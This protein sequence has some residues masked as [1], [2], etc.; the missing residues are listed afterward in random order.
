MDD[1]TKV[2]LILSMVLTCDSLL[3]GR[4]IIM[5]TSR[6]TSSGQ[7][8][9]PEWKKV[10]SKAGCFL[11]FC[12]FT[13][14]MCWAVYLRKISVWT[15]DVCPKMSTREDCNLAPKTWGNLCWW[16]ILPL[17]IAA[18]MISTSCARARDT[19]VHHPERLYFLT[20]HTVSMIMFQ[21]SLFLS[22]PLAYPFVFFENVVDRKNWMVVSLI[23]GVFMIGAYVLG[24]AYWIEG[25]V[26]I[27][28]QPRRRTPRSNLQ[29][30]NA[31]S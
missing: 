25:S 31:F 29:E 8:Y 7:S 11:S 1:L 26:K 30:R 10:Q 24:I 16:L 19:L 18:S 17:F 5:R 22:L 13:V 28:I 15:M 9:T 2:V 12:E 3:L 20:D 23:C 27:W 6:T 14:T 4:F 21:I